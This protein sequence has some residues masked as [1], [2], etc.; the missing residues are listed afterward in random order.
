MFH[1]QNLCG[2][3][4]FVLVHLVTDAD[5][6]AGLVGQC[7]QQLAIVAADGGRN[8]AEFQVPAG[9]ILPQALAVRPSNSE[10]SR[11]EAALWLTAGLH[12]AVQPV[13]A[14]KSCAAVSKAAGSWASG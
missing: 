4:Q 7:L 14:A 13:A 11:R 8:K 12:R 5:P 1:A 9:G 6:P 10:E 3:Q 2:F